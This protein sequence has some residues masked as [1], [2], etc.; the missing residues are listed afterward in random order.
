MGQPSEQDVG[1]SLS[2]NL[3]LIRASELAQYDFCR[4]AWWLGTVKGLP[5]A[6]QASRRR[7]RRKHERH[8]RQVRFAATW[9]RAGYF[10]V[11]LGGL[12]LIAALMWLWLF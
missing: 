8:G 9:R 4:R 7:G 10:L 6:S 3:P 1:N 5:A 12:L 11:G 2:A